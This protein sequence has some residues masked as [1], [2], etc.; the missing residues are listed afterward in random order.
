[1]T[2]FASFS[3]LN[4]VLPVYLIFMVFFFVKFAPFSHL[5]GKYL[6]NLDTENPISLKHYHHC[7]L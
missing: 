1:M 3:V 5:L 7:V 2:L 4:H 6:E